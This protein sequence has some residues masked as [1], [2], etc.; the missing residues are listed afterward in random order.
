VAERLGFGVANI[1]RAAG[2]NIAAANDGVLASAILVADRESDGLKEEKLLGKASMTQ[3][4]TP[5]RIAPVSEWADLPI[6]PPAG[7]YRRWL[8]YPVVATLA[9]TG[10][11]FALGFFWQNETAAT[12]VLVATLAEAAVGIFGA[13]FAFKPY[14]SERRLGYTTWP[15]IAELKKAGLT[16]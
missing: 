10:A 3:P 15:S 1:A 6:Q 7:I 13:A 11:I 8:R 16:K 9:T 4:G 5:L 14:K 12:V 2:W